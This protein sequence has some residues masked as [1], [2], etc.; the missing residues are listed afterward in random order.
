MDRLPSN[1]EDFRIY[2]A[3]CQSLCAHFDEFK[4]FFSNADY[5]TICLTETWLRRSIFDGMVGF[6]GYILFRCDREG[7]GRGGVAFYLSE[8]LHASVLANSSGSPAGRPEFIMAKITLKESAKLLLVVVYRPPNVEYLDEIL[9]L[10]F[11]L[12]MNYRHS[13]I[14]EDFNADLLQRTF[15]SQQLLTFVASSGLHLVP[16]GPTHHC[17][18]SSTLLDFCIIDDPD[19]LIEFGQ[20]GV[21]FLSAQLVT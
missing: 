11:E 18:D 2:H 12:Q 17:R 5:H 20:R 4:L 14:I 16:F 21:P 13:I 6:P 10:F 8:A 3:N 19:K 7:R 9:R 15:D 1:S